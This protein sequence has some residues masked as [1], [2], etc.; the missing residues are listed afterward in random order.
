M[1]MMQGEKYEIIW[2]TMK[3]LATCYIT[4]FQKYRFPGNGLLKTQSKHLWVYMG[5]HNK[6]IKTSPDNALFPFYY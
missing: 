1:Q 5:M 3:V 4:T 6:D 2:L